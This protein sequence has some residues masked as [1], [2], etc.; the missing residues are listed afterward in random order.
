MR[1]EDLEPFSLSRAGDAD[2]QDRE[3]E[4][5]D[6]VPPQL[7]HE[8]RVATFQIPRRSRLPA[9][10]SRSIATSRGSHE[11]LDHQNGDLDAVRCPLLVREVVGVVDT[12]RPRAAAQGSHDSDRPEPLERPPLVV[13]QKPV[14]A[15][16]EVDSVRHCQRPVHFKRADVLPDR[17][18]KGAIR[19]HAVIVRP[20]LARWLLRGRRERRYIFPVFRILHDE[21]VRGLDERMTW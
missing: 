8:L 6:T 10:T 4:V 15:V 7:V 21:P 5:R 2:V 16:G 12:K 3:V 1:V 13:V 19:L 11:R 18:V 17:G 14:R 9:R 20:I